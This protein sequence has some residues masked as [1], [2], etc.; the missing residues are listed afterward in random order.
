MGK[1]YLWLTVISL[2]QI[3]ILFNQTYYN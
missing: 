1:F 3:N 2:L